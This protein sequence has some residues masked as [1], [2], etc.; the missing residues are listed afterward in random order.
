MTRVWP[1]CLTFAL[2]ALPAAA[3]GMQR[4]P[5][6]AD[7][8]GRAF[9]APFKLRYA[10]VQTVLTFAAGQGTASVTAE[11]HPAPNIFR[12]AYINP[13]TS[14]G[15]IEQSDGHVDRL[16]LPAQRLVV[17]SPA[18]RQSAVPGAIRRSIMRLEQNYH[19][20]LAPSVHGV[21]GRAAWRLR[22]TP[23]DHARPRQVLWIDRAT[24]LI[25]RRTCYT[26][27]GA[28]ASRTSWRRLTVG[29]AVPRRLPPWH[30]PPHTRV[31]STEAGSATLATPAAAQRAVTG[32]VVPPAIGGG[33]EFVSAHTMR[34]KGTPGLLVTYSDGMN[35]VS[36]L[37][38]AGRRAIAGSPGDV[39]LRAPAV[40]GR[41]DEREMR[42]G[43]LTMLWWYD[44]RSNST[45]SLQG[46][47]TPQLL[48]KLALNVAPPGSKRR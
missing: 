23:H 13:A 15:R 14:R 22:I 36:L 17:V 12:I 5:T 41:Q 6:A 25:T 3:S 10:C 18:S 31:V 2:A 16:Y 30:V 1:H 28:E 7:A 45:A 26:A 38:L 48:L 8:L 20:Q 37:V 43:M 11:L 40:P 42:R 9:E 33:F 4:P 47:V 35:A 29:G 46:E 21:D 19:L 27:D 44:P 34:A 24:W 32:A 39:A